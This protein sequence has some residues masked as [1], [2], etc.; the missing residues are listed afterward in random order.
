MAASRLATVATTKV[1][2]FGENHGRA[3]VIVIDTFHEFG[4]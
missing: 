3:F 1:I 2:G 4:G